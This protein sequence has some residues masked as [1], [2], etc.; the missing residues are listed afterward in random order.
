MRR[1][2]CHEENKEQGGERRRG[3]VEL[4]ERIAQPSSPS[5][6]FAH[7]TVRLRCFRLALFFVYHGGGA[8]VS[9]LGMG[10]ARMNFQREKTPALPAHYALRARALSIAPLKNRGVRIK[11]V[12]PRSGGHFSAFKG[13][14]RGVH[15]PNPGVAFD[16]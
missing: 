10:T 12:A 6:P 2:G 4:K 7:E 14:F 1:A 9:K 3:E 5:S 15:N 8:A 13:I 11:G 16:L